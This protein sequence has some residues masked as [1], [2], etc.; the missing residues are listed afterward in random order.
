MG[1][2]EDTITTSLSLREEGRY[3]A[4]DLQEGTQ[5]GCLLVLPNPD[6]EIPGNLWMKPRYN[7]VWGGMGPQQSII[8]QSLPLK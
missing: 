8:P 6:W 7:G 2:H 4:A 5:K 1:G 3:E